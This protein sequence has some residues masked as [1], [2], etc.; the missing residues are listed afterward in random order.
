MSATSQPHTSLVTC[1][2]FI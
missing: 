2:D 1:P